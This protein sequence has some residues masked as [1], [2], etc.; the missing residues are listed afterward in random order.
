M[1]DRMKLGVLYYD[2]KV[3]NHRSLLKVILNPI[4]RMFGVCIGTK[5]EDGILGGIIIIKCERV[6]KLRWDFNNHNTY[7]NINKVRLFI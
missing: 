3:V 5:F 1:I 7:N 6:N 2:G 4:L